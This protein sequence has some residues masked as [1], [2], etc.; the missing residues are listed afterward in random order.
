MTEMTFKTAV[1]EGPLDLLLHLIKELEI[2][3]YDIPVAQ[4]TDQ[5]L[6]YIHTMKELQLDI[7]GDY[8]VMAATLLAIKS[9]TLLPKKIVEE[10]LLVEDYEGEDPREELVEQLVAY[11]QFKEVAIDL[12]DKEKE[13]QQLFTKAP[14]PLIEEVALPETE[15]ERVSMADLLGAFH[16]MMR[17]KKLAKPLQTTIARSEISIE[18][19]MNDMI[20]L[21][22]RNKEAV[23]FE[24]LF[25]E[26]SRSMLVVSFLA[27][28]ELMKRQTIT[29]EQEG[30]FAGLMVSLKERQ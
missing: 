18:E 6:E 24:T 23:M 11:K 4:I 7:A 19:R 25:E 27:L 12:K 10:D 26:N 30:S 14:L 28:L 1:F 17:R 16:K 22:S 29:V 15:E 9:R 20:E 5:Y 13:R 8:I 21:I 3:I 2:D